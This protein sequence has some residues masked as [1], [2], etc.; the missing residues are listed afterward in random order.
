MASATAQETGRSRSKFCPDKTNQR[1]AIRG[2]TRVGT[3]WRPPM[4]RVVRL[5]LVVALAVP[6]ALVLAPSA[7]SADSFRVG[8]PTIVDP[9]R[10]A[11]EPDIAVDN[12]GNALITRPG[13]AGSQTSW[14]WHTA[15]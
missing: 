6:V 4:G 1:P 13:G 10:G 8:I 12:D 7:Q 9:I 5:L 15:D 11:G 14:V 2:R 3:S